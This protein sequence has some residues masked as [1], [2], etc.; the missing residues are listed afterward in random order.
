MFYLNNE[1][2]LFMELRDEVVEVLTQNT[3]DIYKKY[4]RFVMFKGKLYK[5][6]PILFFAIDGI[7]MFLSLLLGL[8]FGFDSLSIMLLTIT[9][10]L[11][12]FMMF[13][14]YVAPRLYYKSAKKFIEA[15]NRYRFAKDYM[16]VETNSE[17]SSGTSKIMYEAI[18]KVCEIDEMLLIF[19]SNNQAFTIPKKDCSPEK[20]QA[21]RNI[22]CGK[23][24]KYKNYSKRRY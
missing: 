16:E 24:K 7:G 15:P 2:G 23:V 10:F 21:I 8:F 12:I 4:H 18:H 20:V 6:G 17:L 19:I 22:L 13:L 14:I 1:G 3:Y 5:E 9:V 11:A